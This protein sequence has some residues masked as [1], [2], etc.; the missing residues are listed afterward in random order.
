[1][2]PMKSSSKFVEVVP[3]WLA[4]RALE[5]SRVFLVLEGD[6]EPASPLESM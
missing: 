4:L 5:P 1:M 2:I 3:P 6:D